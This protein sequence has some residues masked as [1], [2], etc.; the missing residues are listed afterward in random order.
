MTK[1]TWNG[2]EVEELE[3][4]QDGALLWIRFRFKDGTKHDTF[5]FKGGL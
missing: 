3:F 5:V 1:V 2:K 4:H